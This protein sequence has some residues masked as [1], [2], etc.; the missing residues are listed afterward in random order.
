MSRFVR[1]SRGSRTLLASYRFQGSVN[2]VRV[3]ASV[4]DLVVSDKVD[5]K[6]GFNFQMFRRF[7]TYKNEDLVLFQKRVV[8]HPGCVSD[9]L[10]DVAAVPDAVVA[11]VL[12]HDR[13]ALV[14]VR[15]G[16]AADSDELRKED[17]KNKTS[18]SG[19]MLSS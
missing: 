14:L 9:H 19:K 12:V 7:Q 2:V 1:I 13:L 11:L 10:V 3:A 16:V 4:G 18:T 17:G 5:L 15:H 8:Q 6:I